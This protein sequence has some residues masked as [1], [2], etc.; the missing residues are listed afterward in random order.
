M[1]K[2]TLFADQARA[3]VPGGQSRA[4]NPDSESTLMLDN[5]GGYA[6]HHGTGTR[7]LLKYMDSSTTLA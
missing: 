1:R 7:C 6:G 2:K 5:C 3:S 4:L